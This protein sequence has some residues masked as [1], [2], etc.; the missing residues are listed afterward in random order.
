MR[1]VFKFFVR[2]SNF[3]KKKVLSAEKKVLFEAKSEKKDL[4]R[5]KGF[6][7]HNK[8]NSTLMK[9]GFTFLK[10]WTEKKKK[11]GFLPSLSIKKVFICRK[12]RFI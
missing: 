10:K 2:K 5:K 12:K 3:Q 1:Y 4:V 11:K 7:Q 9:K 8:R 6:L